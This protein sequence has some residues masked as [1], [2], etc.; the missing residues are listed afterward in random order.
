H[1]GLHAGAARHMAVGSPLTPGPVHFVVTDCSVLDH[2]RR[3]RLV[4]RARHTQW[5]EKVFAREFSKR[6]AG[7][8]F[9]DETQQSVLTASVMES[10]ARLKRQLL[11]AEKHRQQV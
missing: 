8:S 11:L 6:L 7:H 2:A 4:K 3:V 1:A 5:L 10:C 9:D